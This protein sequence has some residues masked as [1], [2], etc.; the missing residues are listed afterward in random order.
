MSALLQ[1][2]TDALNGSTSPPVSARNMIVVENN[3]SDPF[4]ES[5]AAVM[6]RRVFVE[7]LVLSDIQVT[8]TARV[9][10]PVLNSF[11]GTPLRFGAS[12]M[13][14]VFQFPD[15]LLKDIA[16]DYVADAIVRSP[17]LLM[18]L[19]IIGNPAYV[20]VYLMGTALFDKD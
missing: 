3:W 14:N 13:R 9:T 16:A 15:Q 6:Q 18:S 12:R 11:D 17:M 20:C 5:I 2:I 7:E 8:V 4:Q 10:I 1:P 19:N